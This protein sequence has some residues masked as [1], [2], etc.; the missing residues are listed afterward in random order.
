M[1]RY[2]ILVSLLLIGCSEINPF[3]YSN[4]AQFCDIGIRDGVA[5]EEYGIVYCNNGEYYDGN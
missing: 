1:M 2:L 3:E 4:G 5:Y